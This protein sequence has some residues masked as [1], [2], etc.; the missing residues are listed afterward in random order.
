MGR[1][2][3]FLTPAVAASLL[4]AGCGDDESAVLASDAGAPLEARGLAF[5]RSPSMTPEPTEV[6]LSGLTDPSGAL[7][8]EAV[9]VVNCVKDTAATT[10]QLE[11]KARPGP[12]GS[13]LEYGPPSDHG[14]GAPG[15]LDDP[16][17]EVN[18]YYQLTRA[19]AYFARLGAPPRPAPVA[20]VNAMFPVEFPGGADWFPLDNAA[21][22][23]PGFL[24]RTGFEWPSEEPSF[25][26]GQGFFVDWAYD[27][28]T[29]IHEYAHF[30]LGSVDGAA[31][32]RRYA[33]DEQG[34]D[35]LSIA[36]TEA[37]ADYF[38]ASLVGDPA[39]P[40][41][42]Y[43]GLARFFE[44][45]GQ[46]VPI[47]AR[48]RVLSE[49][50]VC[51]DDLLSELH[52]DSRAYSSALWAIREALGADLADRI[53]FE[54][55]MTFPARFTV[56]E[57]IDATLERAE[58]EGGATRAAVEAAFGDRGLIDCRRIKRYE[59]FT[60]AGD[61]EAVHVLGRMEA[62]ASE[63]AGFVPA[64]WQYEVAVP[65]ETRALRL[66]I[67]LDSPGEAPARVSAA[68][69]A[70]QP[71]AYSYA[72]TG[73]AVAADAQIPFTVEGT[74]L[75]AVIAGT[76][77]ARGGSHYFQILNL[78]ETSISIVSSTLELL[79]DAAGI[80]DYDCP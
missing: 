35:P 5:E 63:L 4:L 56:R 38:A 19:H 36:M 60:I 13:Y 37:Y 29:L 66:S 43:G 73:A 64:F 27:A 10:C 2:V 32:F 6:S 58:M 24:A 80:A 46:P 74:S 51:P 52:L 26:I 34:I 14:F 21:Y 3:V 40:E 11:P 15:S 59:D 31:R 23:A 20:I 55:V 48:P 47:R 70:G 65:P 69:R 16:F 8:G 54:S 49:R 68:W 79:D 33:V 44:M 61:Q 28:D 30:V 50:R 53:V 41:Y 57:A 77:L 42:A 78:G 72:G 39:P 76:C 22:V 75:S 67:T 71:V 1:R 25:I 12:D 7:A 17:A 45:A 18:A 9:R 62:E